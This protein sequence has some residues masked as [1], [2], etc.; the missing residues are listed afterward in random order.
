M[1]GDLSVLQRSLP[2]DPA[3][4]GQ[5]IMQAK[6]GL[7]GVGKHHFLKKLIIIDGTT[8]PSNW[9]KELNSV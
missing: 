1:K 2:V 5:N 9:V 8:L 7:G 4:Y 6:P 3:L